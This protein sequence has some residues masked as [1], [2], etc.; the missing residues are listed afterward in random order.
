MAVQD[1]SGAC[2]PQECS[3]RARLS[4]IARVDNDWD[5]PNR[6]CEATFGDAWEWKAGCALLIE[7][8]EYPEVPEVG[9][10][11]LLQQSRGSFCVTLQRYSEGWLAL[12]VTHCPGQRLLPCPPVPSGAGT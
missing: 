6:N 4:V 9:E 7:H 10:R 12:Y 1:T 3:R 5:C 2:L 11:Y 8:P